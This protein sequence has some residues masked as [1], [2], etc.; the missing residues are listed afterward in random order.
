MN[1]QTKQTLVGMAFVVFCTATSFGFSHIF[2]G[3]EKGLADW[4]LSNRPSQ[5]IA[6]SIVL[7]RADEE[8]SA[9]C[10]EGRWNLTILQA[11]FGAL[12]QAGA[13]VIAPMM[14]VSLPVA[15][16]C[17]GLAGFVQLA[18]MT[19]HMGSVVYPDSVPT[20]LAQAAAQT[21]F[22]RLPLH[23]TGTV[24]G[25]TFNSSSLPSPSVPFGVAAASSFKTPVTAPPKDSFLHVPITM[26]KN[27]GV[28]FPRHQFNDVWSLIQAGK[29]EELVR[30]FQGKVVFLYSDSTMSLRPSAAKVSGA[31]VSR[32]HAELANAY[33]TNSWVVSAPFPMAFL[34]ALSLSWLV[35]VPML[36][37]LPLPR[38]G[39]VRGGIVLL[40]G[41]IFFLGFEWGWLWPF[42]SMSLAVGLTIVGMGAWKLWQS[43]L[44][45]HQEIV[46][47]EQQLTQLEQVLSGKQQHVRQ[48]EELLS[49]A[50]QQSNQSGTVIEELQ[51]AQ[52][53][54]LSQ[55]DTYQD[56]V[57]ETRRKIEH[58]QKELFELRQHVPATP[59]ERSPETLTVD[60]QELIQ[61][62]E[63]FQIV[64]RDQAVLRLFHNLKKAAATQ[65]PI[66]LLGETGTGKEVFAKAAH[67]LS[68]RRHG[69]FISVNMA[70]IRAELFEGELF[71]HV[72]GAF[73]G[74]VGRTGF[75]ESAHG[76]TLFLDEVG[77]LPLDLQAKLLR[78][79]EDGGFHRVGQSA[80][81]HVDV[82]IVAATNRDLQ[83]EV[84]AGRYREDL[85][86]RLRSIV[87]TLP[88]LRVR[89]Q[90]D[91]VL[92]AQSF[93]QQCAHSQHR[94]DLAFA[95]G[96]LD[97]IMAYQWPGNIRELRQ[98]IAQA[99][100]LANGS[101][102]T[103]AELNL[104]EPRTSG[105]GE[106]WVKEDV[107]RQEDAMVLECLRRH[108]FEMQATAAT[109]G[110]DRGTV[111]Q[112]LKGLGFQALMEYQG[113]VHAA[114]LALAGDERFVRVVEGRLREYTNNLVPTSKNYGSVE[115]AIA[116]CRKR[117]RNLP[118]RHFPAVE[119]LLHER[120]AAL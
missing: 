78:F 89:S 42:F 56:E 119:Q 48:L 117:F 98:T 2:P 11:T 93:L 59:A 97:A 84:R 120:F 60:D 71:G 47:R 110:W 35:M 76:G 43:R 45:V 99:A 3:G 82:R 19:K 4:Q 24:G 90:A 94:T 108:K 66:L 112:R 96:A 102:I 115:E 111:T 88:P 32:L 23:E 61:E 62:C 16:E 114:A 8:S 85:Y 101:V 15:S 73:T 75:L 100:A 46:R 69:P 28:V 109:L 49:E 54:S 70:A 7:V 91:H 1:L 25:F 118:E 30:S 74:A 113:N 38:L 39:F 95:Q 22:L 12:H 37:E 27:E 36:F 9:L 103:E 72:K 33:L 13:S 26:S 80:V 10:G 106:N 68:P 29:R 14:D 104:E 55:L 51:I 34:M 105:V 81:T 52:N 44:T 64:T 116:D 58:L 63:A 18:E 53:T 57:Q 92:L 77:D 107:G 20:A 65:V 21:G 17:G 79:L 86:Y 6:Q 67:A 83:D 31:S 50:Q 40:V 41:G 5:P 87:L